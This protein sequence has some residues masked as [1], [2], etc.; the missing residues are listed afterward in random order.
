MINNLHKFPSTKKNPH[1]IMKMNDNIN[2]ENTTV[3]LTNACIY[4][5]YK[6]L[7]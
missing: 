4:L 2:M 5:V 3:R 7:F 6:L 1:S